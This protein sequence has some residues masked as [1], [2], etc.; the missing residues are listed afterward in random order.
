MKNNLTQINTKLRQVLP[1]IQKEFD[2]DRVELFGSYLRK[3]QNSKSDLDLLVTFKKTPGL[4]KFLKLE[5]YLSDV[6]QIKVDLVPKDSI[7]PT[8]RNQ[9]LNNT[10]QV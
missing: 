1:F 8:L 10:L 4:F 6:L 7:K 9:I 5:R 2:V 3:E